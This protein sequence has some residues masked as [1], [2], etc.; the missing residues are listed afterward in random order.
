[1]NR[2]LWLAVMAASLG[3]SAHAAPI[4]EASA[5]FTGTVIDFNAFDGLITAGPVDLGQGITLTSTPWAEV[6]ANARALG[7]NGTWTVLGDGVNR[8]GNFLATSFV[9]PRG[10]LGFSFAAPVQQVG[11]FFNQF[12]VAGVTNRLT[13]LA[14]D[15]HGN[16]LE[17]QTVSLDT[18]EFGYDEGR[19]LGFQRATADIHGFAVADGTFV[20]DNL[21]V[22]AVPEPQ[23]L[24]L[25][26]AGAGVSWLGARRR[27][28][29]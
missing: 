3:A 11:A 14:Y 27:R 19:F 23:A 18:D 1:M 17:T 9:S 22:S 15:A 10:E 7:T 4:N 2:Q 12:Q 5:P 24:A 13:L 26:L 25:L 8:D 16:V 21:T 6:G 29:H 28:A 20:M